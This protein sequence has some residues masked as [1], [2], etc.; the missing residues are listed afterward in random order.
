MTNNTPQWIESRRRLLKLMGGG[1]ALASI[2]G[3]TACGGEEQSAPATSPE[4]DA[5]PETAVDTLQ[6]AES[7]TGTAEETTAKQPDA[8]SSSSG[9]GDLPKLSE[10]N[11]QAKAL[12]YRH[13]AQQVDASNYPRYQAG[14]LCSNCSLFQASSGDAW[15]GCSIFPNHLV[16]ADGWCSAY[17]RKA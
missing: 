8:G 1:V 14:Q 7:G 3:L 4:A 17:V 12:G 15:G 13:D 16:N 10:D 5:Q 11:P 9:S 6:P 2:A